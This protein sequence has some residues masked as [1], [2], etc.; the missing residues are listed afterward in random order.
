MFARG[1]VVLTCLDC[2]QDSILKKLHVRLSY[3]KRCGFLTLDHP[4]QPLARS[5][6]TAST[7]FTLLVTRVS[8][9]CR[10]K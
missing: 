9:L 2:A 7:A 1:A 5:C 8:Q 6:Y 10:N 4:R 3:V